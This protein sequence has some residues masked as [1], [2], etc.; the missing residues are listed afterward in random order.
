[1]KNNN[2]MK[3]LVTGGSG[4][5]GTNY[6]EYLIQNGKDDFINIDFQAPR[7]VEHNKY[8]KNCN[9]LD[10]R[11]FKKITKEFSPTHVVHLAAKTGLSNNINDYKTNTEG[12]EILMDILVFLSINQ[13]GLEEEILRGT[14]IP[15]KVLL[16]PSQLKKINCL[17][18]TF[19]LSLLLQVYQKPIN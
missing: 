13:M 9:I 11:K 8:W 14:L 1:M 18:A 7:N 15:I 12:V 19:Y 4:F 5:I 2:K 6:L 3:I 16:S 17:I 10:K